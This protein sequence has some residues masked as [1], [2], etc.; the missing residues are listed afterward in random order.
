MGDVSCR[1][2][3]TARLLPGQ[4]TLYKA[5]G[6]CTWELLK[7]CNGKDKRWAKVVWTATKQ[8][9]RVIA[10]SIGKQRDKGIKEAGPVS[11]E[12]LFSCPALGKHGQQAPHEQQAGLAG[13]QD[14]GTGI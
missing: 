1:I 11:A 8:R 3:Q 10:T 13:G 9:D 7:S 6:K 14:G 12:L 2:L 4:G 5:P